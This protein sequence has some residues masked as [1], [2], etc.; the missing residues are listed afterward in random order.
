M[1]LIS[2]QRSL[3]GRLAALPHAPS[4][5]LRFC[6]RPPAAVLSSTAGSSS[7]PAE[8]PLLVA[9]PSFSGLL[10][11][12]MQRA[13]HLPRN[14]NTPD[15]KRR[16]LVTTPIFYV[17][18]APHIGHMFTCVLADAFARWR[19]LCGDDVYL[20]SGTDEHGLKVR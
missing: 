16:I 12:L 13:V 10:A 9:R 2:M 15:S 1:R 4:L 20:T 6:L 11:H 3:A 19:R 5:S 14:N 18:G 7:P 8:P 17:N